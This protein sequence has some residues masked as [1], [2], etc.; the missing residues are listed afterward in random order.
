MIAAYIQQS[1][2]ISGNKDSEVNKQFQR[3]YNHYQDRKQHNQK[4]KIE[5]DFT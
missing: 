3:D 2:G 1:Y 5:Y 4:E